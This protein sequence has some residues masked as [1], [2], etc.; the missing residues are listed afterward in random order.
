MSDTKISA[1]NPLTTPSVSSDGSKEHFPLAQKQVGNTYSTF[2]VTLTNLLSWM[3]A[4]IFP[5]KVYEIVIPI[6]TGTNAPTIDIVK[7]ELGA[8]V[9]WTRDSTGYYKGVLAG[10]FPFGKVTL[11]IHNP[12]FTHTSFSREDDDTI[13]INTTTDPTTTTQ[14]DGKLINCHIQVKV[15]P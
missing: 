13:S 3:K 2:R 1:L 12:V 15:Y 9:V 4:R 7:N 6:Q 5:A 11:A 8:A 10:A 14:S